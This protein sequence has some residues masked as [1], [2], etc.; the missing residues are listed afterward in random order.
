[1]E[2]DLEAKKEQISKVMKTYPDFPRKGVNFVDYF[3]ILYCPE[4]TKILHEVTI[5]VI[6]KFY[7]NKDKFDVVVGLE[8]RGFILG[9]VIS[10]HYNIPFVPIRKKGK[11]PGKCISS[12]YET[13]YSKDAV[14]IQEHALSE[15]NQVLIVD[16]LLATGGTLKV[17]TDLVKGLKAKVSACFVIFELEALKGREKLDEPDNLI[18][19]FKS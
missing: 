8:T 19:I 2:N 6:D 12:D 11:L 10:Q 15:S 17:A 1:M 4:E 14:E 18:T 3:S 9:M 16:D 13:E 7:A 5:E